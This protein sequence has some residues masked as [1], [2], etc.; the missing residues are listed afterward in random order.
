MVSICTLIN[1]RSYR[2][3]ASKS[4]EPITKTTHMSI[5]KWVQKYASLTDRFV[6]GIEELDVFVDDFTK[7]KWRELLLLSVMVIS[8]YKPN[9][10]VCLLFHI[11]RER[12]TIIFVC[13]QFFN[14]VRTRFG[15]KLIIIIFTDGAQ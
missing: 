14:Q 9:L 6:I 2:R 4:L 8:T 7:D 1:S 13:Y 12:N 3:F 5:C 10:H 11:S 15:N